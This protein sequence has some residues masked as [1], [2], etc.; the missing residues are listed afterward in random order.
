MTWNFSSPA[1]PH[2]GGIWERLIGM[3]KRVPSSVLKQKTPD[4]EGLQTILCEV[5]A[6]LNDRPI[7]RMSDDLEALTPNH[8]LLRT[9]PV[10]PSGVFDH[11][12]Q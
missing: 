7:T 4:D 11:K 5:E 2:Q 3:V 6:M 8:I 9:K 1:A 12:D 10:L